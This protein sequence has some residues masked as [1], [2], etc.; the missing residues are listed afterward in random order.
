MN[1]MVDFIIKECSNESV[2]VDDA[3][4]KQQNTSV[5]SIAIVNKDEEDEGMNCSF[6]LQD[7]GY[8]QG[9]M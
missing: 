8:Y 7:E 9:T 3:E 6:S 4:N 2:D 1:S 5:E